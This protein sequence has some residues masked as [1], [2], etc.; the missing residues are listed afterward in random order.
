MTCVFLMFVDKLSSAWTIEGAFEKA[1]FVKHDAASHSQYCAFV[2]FVP[3]VSQT[4][5]NVPLLCTWSADTSEQPIKIWI[6]GNSDAEEELEGKK[7]KKKRPSNCPFA[8]NL[9]KTESLPAKSPDIWNVGNYHFCL[10]TQ[11][12]RL[13]ILD[14]PTFSGK[15]PRNEPN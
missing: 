13:K 1:L 10:H 12:H 11:Y 15:T 2:D 8:T 7:D 14:G 9:Y 6:L 3:L 4:R 5:H